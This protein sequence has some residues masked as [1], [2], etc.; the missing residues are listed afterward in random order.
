MTPPPTRRCRTCRRGR[1]RPTAAP[2]MCSASAP[3]SASLRDRAPGRRGRARPEHDAAERHV[4][5]P[6]LGASRIRPVAVAHEA[7]DADADADQRARSSATLATT[8]PDQSGDGAADLPRLAVRRGSAPAPAAAPRPPSPT[9]ATTARSTP[10]STAMTNGPSVAMPTPAD[11]PAGARR[12]PPPG[13]LARS[14]RA[15][16]SSRTSAGDG[17]AVQPHQARSARRARSGRRWCTCRSSGRRG[18]GG[19][20]PPGWCPCPTPAAGQRTAR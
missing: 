13:A 17:A 4:V 3:R 5:P 14:C 1:R 10:R 20:R 6:R 9:R 18:C 7:G 2:R 11:G 12:V 8:Q 19:A 16:S 15:S